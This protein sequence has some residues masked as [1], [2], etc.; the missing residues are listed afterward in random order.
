MAGSESAKKVNAL[1]TDR[2]NAKK[3]SHKIELN[4]H[5]FDLIYFYEL[6]EEM[7]PAILIGESYQEVRLILLI[8]AIHT[9][10]GK[11]CINLGEINTQYR[12]FAKNKKAMIYAMLCKLQDLGTVTILDNESASHFVGKK[13]TKGKYIY[14]TDKGVELAIALMEQVA[15][16]GKRLAERKGVILT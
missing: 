4:S 5:V 13:L 2:Y 12:I 16:A 10:L 9:Q 11:R 15:A 8:N 1:I 3:Q 7:R 6:I 14:L